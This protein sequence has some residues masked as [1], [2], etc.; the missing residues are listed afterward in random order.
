MNAVAYGTVG[1]EQAL[2][3]TAVKTSAYTASPGDLVACDI[4]G[5]GFTVELPQAP[6]D[7]TRVAVKV[8]NTAP[9]DQYLLTVSTQGSDVLNKAGGLTSGTRVLLNQGA[10]YQYQLSTG[11]WYVTTDDLPLTG[12]KDLIP[13]WLNVTLYGADPTGVADSTAAVQAVL[14]HGVHCVTRPAAGLTIQLA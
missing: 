1:A 7:Q 9:L 14:W 10:I 12:V 4:S 13:D 8:I 2:T 5:G 6:A 11:I 3:P